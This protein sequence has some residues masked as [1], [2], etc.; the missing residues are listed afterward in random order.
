MGPDAYNCWGLARSVRHEVY[1][2]PLLPEYGRH[3]QAS[4]Q[5][6]RDYRFQADLL[7]ECRPEPG[8]IAAVFRGQLCIHVG[9][10]IEVEGRLA[11][12]ETNQLSGCRWLRVPDFERRYLR[13]I[14]YRDRA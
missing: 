2:L 5:A 14:Y 1:G 13:V 3:V 4:P 8:A 6:Q 11:V 10:V 12:L 9:V 7:E